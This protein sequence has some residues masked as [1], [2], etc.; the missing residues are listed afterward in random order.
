MPSHPSFF[1]FTLLSFIFLSFSSLFIF[2]SP[3]MPFFTPPLLHFFT[4]YTLLCFNSHLF[5]PFYFSNPL[6][7][8]SPSAP[9]I[10]PFYHIFPHLP[11]FPSF[12]YLFPFLLFLTLFPLFPFFQ[13][14]L[15][16]SFLLPS[17]FP[18]DTKVWEN[19]EFISLISDPCRLWIRIRNPYNSYPRTN[20][21]LSAG[22][23]FSPSASDSILS[24]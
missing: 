4:P 2:P 20:S 14:F 22:G 10:T 11:C 15:S 12:P 16:L 1:P 21:T 13:F 6:I 8:P 5:L 18:Q 9:I 7:F 19:Y 24:E 17:T 3:S 23:S